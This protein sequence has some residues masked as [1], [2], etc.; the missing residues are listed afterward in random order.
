VRAR[1]V[2]TSYARVYQE[3]SDVDWSEVAKE[4]EKVPALRAN[5]R[6]FDCGSRDETA[7]ASAQDDNFYINPSLKLKL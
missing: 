7:R 6:S 4:L 1:G 2:A 5:H 3:W